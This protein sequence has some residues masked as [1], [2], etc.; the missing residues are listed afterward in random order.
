MY[1]YYNINRLL[2]NI[3]KES[4]LLEVYFFLKLEK[5]CLT[6][7]C[8][9]LLCNKVHQ[10][11]VYTNPLPL[12]PSHPLTKSHSSRSI[13]ECWALCAAEFVE[14]TFALCFLASLLGILTLQ[15]TMGGE[16]KA[17]WMSWVD[18]I[19]QLCHRKT[20]LISTI[21]NKIPLWTLDC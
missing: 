1:I 5:S 21:T 18:T 10:L 9:F 20:L 6:M 8:W 15:H 19:R 14:M 12:G 3:T 16:V 13:T 7:S 2:T 17:I 11:Y 4:C